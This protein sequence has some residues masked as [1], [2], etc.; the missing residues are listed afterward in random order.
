MKSGSVKYL[1]CS[2]EVSLLSHEPEPDF[3]VN[4]S[5]VEAVTERGVEL[6]RLRP[7]LPKNCVKLFPNYPVYTQDGTFA[8]HV[9]NAELSDFK[10]VRLITDKNAIFP[11]T[12]VAACA[13]AVI[14][15]KSQP[16]P[17]GQRI[18]APV[19]SS[20][21]NKN[22]PTVTRSVLKNAIENKAL[23]RLTLSLAPFSLHVL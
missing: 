6:S 1:L 11:F 14:L 13:D 21:L 10:L 20:F 4:L 7:V 8:G 9:L 23:I 17:L 16:Y 12:S 18:P 15:K 19:V 3:A 2:S 5:A 22:E